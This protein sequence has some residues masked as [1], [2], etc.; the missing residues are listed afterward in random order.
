MRD[1]VNKYEQQKNVINVLLNYLNCLQ[2][3]VENICQILWHRYLDCEIFIEVLQQEDKLEWLKSM[4]LDEYGKHTFEKPFVSVADFYKNTK[5]VLIVLQNSEAS[6][7]R[8]AVFDTWVNMN[9][10]DVSADYFKQALQKDRE[11]AAR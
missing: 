4:D 8:P 5:D 10:Y 6:G 2:S 11:F 7:T 3:R 1:D 9:S